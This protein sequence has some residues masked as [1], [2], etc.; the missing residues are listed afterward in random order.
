MLLIGQLQHSTF[1]YFCMTANCAFYFSYFIWPWNRQ[2]NAQWARHDHKPNLNM[3][4]RTPLWSR[5]ILYHSEWVYLIFCDNDWMTVQYPLHNDLETI[6][7]WFYITI[8][9]MFCSIESD[10]FDISTPLSRSQHPV[11]ASVVTCENPSQ[12]SCKRWKIALRERE[13]GRLG[14]SDRAGAGCLS[15]CSCF[16][17]ILCADTQAGC[18]MGTEIADCS[19]PDPL[20][21]LSLSWPICWARGYW[22]VGRGMDDQW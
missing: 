14:G 4:I 22:G 8:T 2:D 19:G 1:K 17:N 5:L 13:S 10:L 9:E 18:E 11:K 7:N 20:F 21:Y 15:V 12:A 3:V 16:N 6:R